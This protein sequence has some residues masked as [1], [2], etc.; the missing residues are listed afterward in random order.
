[1][2]SNCVAS[3]FHQTSSV[4]SQTGPSQTVLPHTVPDTDI[5]LSFVRPSHT[6]VKK[7]ALKSP[8][9]KRFKKAGPVRLDHSPSSLGKTGLPPTEEVLS[10]PPMART[11]F[12]TPVTVTS[13]SAIVAA[14]PKASIVSLIWRIKRLPRM[15]KV[16]VKF[17]DYSHSMV[18]SGYV[19]NDQEQFFLTGFKEYYE[20]K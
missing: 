2:Q 18:H 19:L 17:S 12:D 15:R 9:A 10:T 4:P 1:M 6:R 11:L 14:A 5:G 8:R 13:G 16:P 7:A 3:V 20:S